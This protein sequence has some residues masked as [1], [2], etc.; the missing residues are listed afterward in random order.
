[1]RE[2][3]SQVV[4]ILDHTL[5]LDSDFRVY[6][7]MSWREAVS[8]LTGPELLALTYRLT[9]YQGVVSARITAQRAEAEAANRRATGGQ[10]VRRV[11][12]STAEA[13]RA[14]MGDLFEIGG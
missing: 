4:W 10:E 2:R 9:A 13:L 11:I 3:V 12:P 1:M 8:T 6:H 5:D 14:N 7:R